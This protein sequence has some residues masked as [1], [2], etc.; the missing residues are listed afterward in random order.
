M[1]GHPVGPDP[2][3]EGAH[4]EPPVVAC[5]RPPNVGRTR[6]EPG[7][8]VWPDAPLPG[9]VPKML[10]G[11]GAACLTTPG[12]SFVVPEPGTRSAALAAFGSP[13]HEVAATAPK[14]AVPAMP[15]TAAVV[16]RPR[17]RAMAPSRRRMWGRGSV[18]TNGVSLVDP[19]GSVTGSAK[20][21]SSITRAPG[22]S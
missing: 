1:N 21:S 15:A 20:K 4:R 6:V 13:D 2:R 5:E 19:L 12:L 14:T 9:S 7:V 17:K 16:V 10:P 3:E 11:S 8:V 22:S 18:G